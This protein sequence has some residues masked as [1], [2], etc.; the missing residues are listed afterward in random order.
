MTRSIPVVIATAWAMASIGSELRLLVDA[1]RIRDT[2]RVRDKLHKKPTASFAAG[3]LNI[4]ELKKSF[5]QAL[6]KSFAGTD[7]HCGDAQQCKA[8]CQKPWPRQ[9]KNSCEGEVSKMEAYW[10]A[11][12][13]YDETKSY[14]RTNWCGNAIEACQPVDYWMDRTCPIRFYEQLLR[15]D[16]R[17]YRAYGPHCSLGWCITHTDYKVS[18][19]YGEHMACPEKTRTKAFGPVPLPSGITVSE[20]NMCADGLR[21]DPATNLCV[22]LTEANYTRYYNAVRTPCAESRT[23]AAPM[24]MNEPD[25]IGAMMNAGLLAAA[26][27]EVYNCEERCKR[28]ARCKA[29]QDEVMEAVRV[30]V[31]LIAKEKPYTALGFFPPRPEDSLSCD[32][33]GQCYYAEKAPCT[34]SVGTN[35]CQP[36]FSCKSGY[37]Q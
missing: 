21:C 34:W 18:A 14:L 8:L 22:G 36:G 30:R 20:S 16:D 28:D 11:Q 15:G 37:C 25:G 31:D 12:D 27:G 26:R 35:Y 2:K 1:R 10:E 3:G 32:E 33:S 19:F 7:T 6:N 9:E 23:E 4:D 5:G 24:S 13:K 17:G 29:K